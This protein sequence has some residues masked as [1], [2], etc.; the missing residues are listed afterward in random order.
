MKRILIILAVVALIP[1][2]SGCSAKY[3]DNPVGFDQPDPGY[4]YHVNV[5]TMPGMMF[6]FKPYDQ[7]YYYSAWQFEELVKT[8][9]FKK[10]KGPAVGLYYDP[11]WLDKLPTFDDDPFGRKLEVGTRTA[12]L[13]DPPTPYRVKI[14][15][16]VKV[17]SA[18]H[19]GEIRDCWFALKAIEKYM[20]ENN[21][22]KADGPV[23]VIYMN[24][25]PGLTKEKLLTEV[26]VPV[27]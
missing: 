17:V 25:K 2:L 23:R 10:A 12:T 9:M 8:P 21:L 14:L 19:Q 26:Q 4:E 15:I 16:P 20:A 3:Q 13:F 1:V 7:G 6:M 27:L 24:L 5:K 18:L 22:K 11:P